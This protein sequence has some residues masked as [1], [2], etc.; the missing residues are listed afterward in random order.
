M[1]SFRSLPVFSPAIIGVFRRG[2]DAFRLTHAIGAV[3]DAAAAARALGDP[4]NRERH[5][6]ALAFLE[7]LQPRQQERI[8][9]AY[10][11]EAR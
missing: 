10:D 1:A 6:Q 5:A 7:G 2:E 9:A 4:F 3:P 8:L 11:R